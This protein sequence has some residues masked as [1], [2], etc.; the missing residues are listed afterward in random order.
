MPRYKLVVEYDGGSFSGWQRQRNAPSV[1]AVVEEAVAR[2]VGREVRITCAGRTD[3]GVH[4]SHQV[5]H[6]DLDRA[7]RTDT[8]RDATNAH[9]RPHP[10]AIVSAEEVAADFDARRSAIRRHY[11]YRILNRRAP[12]ALDWARL[13]HLPQPLDEGR[14]AEGAASLLGRHDFTTFRASEC[15]AASPVR[16]LERLDVT[17]EGDRVTVEAAA[18]SFLHS[19]VRSLVGTLAQVGTG[20]WAVADVALALAAR[21]RARCGPLAPP[22]GLTLVGVDYAEK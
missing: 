17:R 18:R 21:D 12:P 11:R 1:Q 5:V 8:L 16:T 7:W 6:L 20:R 2:F 14:M 9:L 19:Q 15:Q 10:V 22:H 3:T 4:A 13:W